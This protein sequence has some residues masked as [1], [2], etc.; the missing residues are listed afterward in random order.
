MKKTSH[1]LYVRG[2]FSFVPFEMTHFSFDKL[3]SNEAIDL[4]LLLFYNQTS[5][6]LNKS[7]LLALL[8]QG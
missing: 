8:Q 3:R 7:T 4:Y 5:S 6:N 2:L 1:V